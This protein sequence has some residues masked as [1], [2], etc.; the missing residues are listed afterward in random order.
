MESKGMNRLTRAI[1][2][3]LIVCVTVTYI[4][5]GVYGTR[6]VAY[7]TE[8][9]VSEDDDGSGGDEAPPGDEDESESSSIPNDVL[10]DIEK[11]LIIRDTL[12]GDGTINNPYEIWN[13]EDLRGVCENDPSCYILMQDIDLKGADWRPIGYWDWYPFIGYF[14]GNGHV[15]K[16]F[17]VGGAGRDSWDTSAGGLFGFV[18]GR[19]ENLGIENITNSSDLYEMPSFADKNNRKGINFAGRAG[20][21]AG[22]ANAPAEI[23]NCYYVGPVQGVGGS[24]GLIGMAYPGTVIENCCAIGNVNGATYFDFVWDNGATEAKIGFDKAWSVIMWAVPNGTGVIVDLSTGNV[25]SGILGFVDMLVTF[26][27]DTLFNSE[28]DQSG[29][30]N[31]VGGLIGVNIDGQVKNSYASANVSSNNAVFDGVPTG[32]L[33]GHNIGEDNVSGCAYDASRSGISSSSLN[34]DVTKLSYVKD[35]GI[36]GKD[37]I[38][39]GSWKILFGGFFVP[40]LSSM[41]NTNTLYRTIT[42]L[43]KV[44]AIEVLKNT[45]YKESRV[46]LR[47]RPDSV[48]GTAIIRYNNKDYIKLYGEND[49]NGTYYL[50]GEDGIAT[51]VDAIN[52][53]NSL[54]GEIEENGKSIGANYCTKCHELYC[55]YFDEKD[56][57]EKQKLLSQIA[58]TGTYQDGTERHPYHIHDLDAMIT[59]QDNKESHFLLCSDVDFKVSD[60]TNTVQKYWWPVG[61]SHTSPFK[62][63]LK[64]NAAFYDGDSG[65]EWNLSGIEENEDGY[66]EFD[67]YKIQDVY[68]FKDSSGNEENYI[69]AR[70]VDLKNVPAIKNLKVQ[71]YKNAGLFACLRG[72]VSGIKV[73]L[74]EGESV[75]TIGD[76]ASAGAIAG[77][78]INGA[79]IENCIIVDSNIFNGDGTKKSAPM[80]TVLG[81]NKAGGIAGVINRGVV[82]KNNKTYV[83]VSVENYTMRFQLDP[84]GHNLKIVSYVTRIVDDAISMVKNVW[85]LKQGLDNLWAKK[86]KAENVIEKNTKSSNE[87]IEKVISESETAVDIEKDI[88]AIEEKNKKIKEL[89]EQKNGAIKRLNTI[90]ELNLKDQNVRKEY[91]DIVEK[92]GNEIN[93][94]KSQ[95]EESKADKETLNK[96]MKLAQDSVKE[97]HQTN[98][99]IE[100]II[101][102]S[103]GSYLKFVKR[104]DNGELIKNTK[105]LYSKESQYNVFYDR[106]NEVLNT[107]L[108]NSLNNLQ[109]ELKTDPKNAESLSGFK[110]KYWKQLTE[111]KDTEDIFG[112][113]KFTNGDKNAGE[114]ESHKYVEYTA[115]YV[116][117]GEKKYENFKIDIT[118]SFDELGLEG[119]YIKAADEENKKSANL[120]SPVVDVYPAVGELLEYFFGAYSGIFTGQLW[121]SNEGAKDYGGLLDLSHR[122]LT[123]GLNFKHGATFGGT[124][125]D[126]ERGINANNLLNLYSSGKI[127]FNDSKSISEV[128]GGATLFNGLKQVQVDSISNDG[129]VNALNKTYAS[130]TAFASGSGT[131]NDPYI[132]TNMEHLRNVKY[133]YKSAYYYK[134]GAD[135][136]MGNYRDTYG[137]YWTPIGTDAD[138]FAFEGVFDGNEHTI[139]NLEVHSSGAGGLFGYCAGTIKDLTMENVIIN[140]TGM[141]AGGIAA[142]LCSG[143]LI[144]DCKVTGS[145]GADGKKTSEIISPG[146]VGGIVGISHYG[147]V[148]NDVTVDENVSIGNDYVNHANTAEDAGQGGAAGSDTQFNGIASWL[149]KLLGILPQAMSIAA[150]FVGGNVG[151]GTAGIVNGFMDS[152]SEGVANSYLANCGRV[153][154]L[155]DGK[156]LG[157]TA[158]TT[159]YAVDAV[160]NIGKVFTHKDDSVVESSEA[161][162]SIPDRGAHVPEKNED[163]VYEIKTPNE[164]AYVTYGTC[165]DYILMDDIYLQKC[166]ETGL[167]CG[168]N[169]CAGK[170]VDWYNWAPLCRERDQ[171]FE[172]DFNG[173]GHTIYGLDVHTDEAGGLFG[174]IL[175]D[176]HDLKIAVKDV[177]AYGPAGGLAAAV[178]YPGSVERCAVVPLENMSENDITGGANDDGAGVG[179]LVGIVGKDASVSDSYA[180][181]NVDNANFMKHIDWREDNSYNVVRSSA[182]QV[183][184]MGGGVYDFIKNDLGD[185]QDGNKSAGDLVNT[186][187]DLIFN[188]IL[189]PFIEALV[190][191]LFENSERWYDAAVG[192]LV[193]ELQGN[194]YNSFA[195]SSVTKC[196]LAAFSSKWKAVNDKW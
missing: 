40:G 138:Y 194:V 128:F 49:E 182:S 129:V 171:C 145:I 166:S 103:S 105:D 104:D 74:A 76:T 32:G 31:Y 39:K 178:L 57:D 151:S 183:I 1:V 139:K 143:G 150:S 79:V 60:G 44:Q 13:A 62:G 106:C 86:K 5:F 132:I 186:I 140:T 172:G 146:R 68:V 196:N 6:S 88:N 113:I 174:Y 144:V 72:Q 117:N 108:N 179:G 35:S 2:I 125:S 130:T 10:K 111:F 80:S 12:E 50:I 122:C 185:I 95:I 47:T 14:N 126:T 45:Y 8:T 18:E 69:A 75:S 131:Y 20:G 15:I 56:E 92:C 59:M 61:R 91:E 169:K 98:A 158:D 114:D 37:G 25:L 42:S 11:K 121:G 160:P 55:K 46:L 163:G 73:Q 70:P 9:Q 99:A 137:E 96:T 26:P 93:D 136:D 181:M 148:I 184:N 156:L 81:S 177:D 147:S 66:A 112:K 159:T 36:F 82:A 152:A 43:S 155:H 189:D 67:E 162:E 34:Y 187:I 110:E 109:K 83:N 153:I 193:G 191:P 167:K 157:F 101:D 142:E 52:S 141:S 161:M 170:C 51:N 78:T 175:G 115:V 195:Y 64:N 135:I 85:T 90:E 188:T 102:N 48:T 123:E 165:D 154:G 27:Y 16:N 89:E 164:L 118:D 176:V 53:G 97:I 28:K 65:N 116:E 127:E 119:V 149:D 19:I 71:T 54:F 190:K 24:G 58:V 173:N 30:T 133:F 29:R 124:D 107:T 22:V 21:L 94:I 38:I 87:I 17:Y 168:E 33:I 63:S 7:G 192:G 77:D 180:H 3:L 23:I 4:P 84:V 41:K 134:L 100:Y 120:L